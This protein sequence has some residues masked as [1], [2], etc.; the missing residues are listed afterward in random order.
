MKKII[1]IFLICFVV[2]SSIIFSKKYFSKK[3]KPIAVTVMKDEKLE[4]PSENN[5]IKNLKYEINLNQ[6]KNY[7]ITSELSEIIN[8]DNSELVKMKTVNAQII[9]E[10]KIP[11]LI[12]SDDAEYNNTNYNT[13]F[14]N[15]VLI[16]YM[17]NEIYSDNLDLDINNN[18]IIIFGN[19]RYI[20]ENGT[21]KSD[22]I[23]VNLITKE[24]DI[25]ME[26]KLK[27]VE[28]NKY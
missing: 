27:N 21:V 8:F 5:I 9:D 7:I 2:L 16:Q 6:K 24:I 20:G 4:Q 11:I 14:R 23:K 3:N 25:Y 10:K 26:S 15:N 18:F 13:K 1:Q 22:I 28:V 19:V 17:N 12:T